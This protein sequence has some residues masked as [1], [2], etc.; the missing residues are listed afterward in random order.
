MAGGTVVVTGG[1]RGIGAAISRRLA[2]DG[3]AVAVNYRSDEAA[4][5]ALVGEIERGGGRALACRADV[6]VEADI[7]ALFERAAQLGP[8]AGLV[9]NAG[10]LGDLRRIDE[11]DAASLTA[12]FAAN[13]VGA[14][15]CAKHAVRAMSTK[16]GGRG[17]AIVNVGSIAA[18]NGGIA[19]MV[20]YSASKGALHAL[21]IGLAKEVAREGIR[22]NAVS[23]GMIIT[24]MTQG[25]AGQVGPTVPVGRC[26]EPHEIAAAVAWLLSDEASY[27]VGSIL[28]VSGGR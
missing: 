28:T 21:T 22:V 4:A 17:G 6:A 12:V 25:F 10:I 18:V 15:L 11:H 9:N 20:A 13:V 5:Q 27:A 24:D 23:P 16:H 2:A 14:A 19:G 3:Y 8:L 26:G 7:A 1:G